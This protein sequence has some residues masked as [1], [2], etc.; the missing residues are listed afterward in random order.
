MA[1]CPYLEFVGSGN[2]FSSTESDYL[3]KL[4]G[5]TMDLY[6]EKVKYT[7][8]REYGEEYKSCLVYKSHY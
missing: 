3:C 2:I 8:N 6:S 7:C 4:S 5:Q 1:R